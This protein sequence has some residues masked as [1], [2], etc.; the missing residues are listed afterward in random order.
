MKGHGTGSWLK[1]DAGSIKYGIPPHHQDGTRDF[2]DRFSDELERSPIPCFFGSQIF[3]VFS[4]LVFFWRWI[5]YAWT[6]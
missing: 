2:L 1:I 3:F 6:K 4:D 5:R